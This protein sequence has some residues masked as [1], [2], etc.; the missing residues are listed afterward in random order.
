[1]AGVEGSGVHAGDGD[2]EEQVE[3]FQY[4]WN[5]DTVKMDLEFITGHTYRM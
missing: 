3:G 2:E 5:E 1:M 4:G